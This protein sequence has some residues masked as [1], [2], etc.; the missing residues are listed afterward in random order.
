MS[1]KE[2]LWISNKLQSCEYEHYEIS[3]FA[4][5]EK[6]LFITLIIGSNCHM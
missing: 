3:N 4:F 2:F 1:E 6:N 5:K